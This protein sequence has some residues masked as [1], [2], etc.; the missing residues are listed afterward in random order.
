MM[1]ERIRELAEQADLC[2]IN[3]EGKL[4]SHFENFADMDNEVKKFAELIVRECI[5]QCEQVATAADAKSKSKFVTDD[6]RMLHEGMWGG[7]KN[8]SGQIKQHFGVAE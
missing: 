8:C 5:T 2:F 3:H 7:A 4:T 1:N 6:G